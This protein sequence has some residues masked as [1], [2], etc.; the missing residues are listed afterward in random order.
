MIATTENHTYGA[1]L[2]PEKLRYL[3]RHLLTRQGS[4]DGQSEEAATPICIW[5]THGLGK[6]Q[7]V[8]DLAKEM[9]WS[10]AYCAP[11]QFE[12][13]GDFHGLP[14]VDKSEAASG[15]RVT[16]FRPPDW[17]PTT[18]GPGILLIDDINR[19]D[20]RI[21]RG[22]MQL[23]QRREMFS[24]GLLEGWHIVATANPDNG[25]YSVTPMDDAMIT[26]FFHVSLAFDHRE[27]ARWAEQAR[28]DPRGINF[29]LTYPELVNCGRTT[30][31]TLTQFFTAI[32]DIDDVW[33]QSDLVQTIGLSTLDAPT[34]AAF[35]AFAGDDLKRLVEPTEILSARQFSKVEER[36]RGIAKTGEGSLRVDRL[37]V[38]G[39]RLCFHVLNENRVFNTHDALNLLKFL[40]LDL[41]PNDLRMTIVGDLRTSSSDAVQRVLREKSLAQLI[42]E[43]M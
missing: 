36:L 32:R 37:S 35:L 30:P 8:T 25:D 4:A 20:E 6:T 21:L 42:L 10:L 2:S 28:V 15:E 13:M 38:I 14:E 11:A 31:R 9:G 17:V 5:G 26:R 19:A 3:L 34:V 27:W 40:T 24:W 18:P 43:E 23:I 1:T 7:I 29:V 33:S 39:T 41:L 16:R 12:E 22:L